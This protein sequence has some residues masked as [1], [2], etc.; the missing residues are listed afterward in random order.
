MRLHKKKKEKGK[1]V[2]ELGTEY[3]WSEISDSMYRL[4]KGT[5]VTMLFHDEKIHVL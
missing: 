1:W 2:S 3:K 4:L 5:S